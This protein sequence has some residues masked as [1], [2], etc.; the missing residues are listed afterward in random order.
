M[1]AS[2]GTT[3]TLDSTPNLQLITSFVVDPQTLAPQFLL[4]LGI[5]NTRFQ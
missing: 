4:D 1:K 3:P 2:F 5:R